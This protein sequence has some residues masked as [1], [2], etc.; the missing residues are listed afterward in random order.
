MH[1]NRAFFATVGATFLRHAVG[2]PVEQSNIFTLKTVKSDGSAEYITVALGNDIVSGM[3]NHIGKRSEKGLSK[4][5]ESQYLNFDPNDPTDQ[6]HLSQLQTGWRDGI[7]MASLAYNDLDYNGDT[8][9]SYFAN[10]DQDKVKN[11]FGNIYGNNDAAGSIY[12]G[13]VFWEKSDVATRCTAVDQE[14]EGETVV[15]AYVGN[16]VIGGQDVVL[17]H[18][19]DQAYKLPSLNEVPCDSLETTVNT[20]MNVLGATLLHEWAHYDVIGGNAVGAHI[21]DHGA[22]GYGPLAVRSLPDADKLLNADNYRWLALENYWTITCGRVFSG[23][24]DERDTHEDECGL[25]TCDIQ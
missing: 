15:L 6:V 18:V 17:G 23:P 22:A 12:L 19:C 25:G 4:R 2:A 13:F 8:Y 3:S 11:V 5:L 7:N 14:Q 9:N 21:E 16:I 24:R 10:T 1:L 20:A